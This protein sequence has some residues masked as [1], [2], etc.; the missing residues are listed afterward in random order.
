MQYY[1]EK[2]AYLE[3]DHLVQVTYDMPAFLG[4]FIRTFTNGSDEGG[5]APHK[6]GT[7]RQYV[8]TLKSFLNVMLKGLEGDFFILANGD[9]KKQLQRLQELTPQKLDDFLSGDK[10]LEDSSTRNK[11]HAI[12]AFYSYLYSQDLISINPIADYKAKL[13]KRKPKKKVF[14]SSSDKEKLY[15]T[16]VNKKGITGVKEMDIATKCALRNAII[17]LLITEIGFKVSD[18][19]ALDVEDYNVEMHTL[20]NASLQKYVKLNKRLVSLLD[21]YMEPS[22]GGHSYNN[23]TRSS[24]HP[25][26]Y[27]QALFIGRKRERLAERSVIYML[28]SSIR[29]AFGDNSGFTAENIR[30]KDFSLMDVNT[31]PSPPIP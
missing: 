10:V 8:N 5:I 2:K 29:R 30:N 27:E 7:V 18:I 28:S 14:F 25:F 13:G 20:K 24:F 6:I 1:L 4:S 11:V 12:K 9:E 15:N 19:V 17:M 23:G 22:S 3:N 16:I 31:A 26:I 21:D